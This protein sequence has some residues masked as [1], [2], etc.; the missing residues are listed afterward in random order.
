MLS[1]LYVVL[2]GGWVVLY[3]QDVDGLLPLAGGDGRLD[4]FEGVAERRTERRFSA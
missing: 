3:V 2:G 1:D 4:G